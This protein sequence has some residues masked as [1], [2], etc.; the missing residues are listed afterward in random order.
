[1]LAVKKDAPDLLG[2][3]AQALFEKHRASDDVMIPK[4]VTDAIKQAL[5]VDPD[6]TRALFTRAMVFKRSGDMKKALAYFKRITQ[7]DPRHIE[8]QREVRL[9][10]LRADQE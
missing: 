8:A 1:M 5:D 4:L 6:N 10:K 3:R 9:A 2:L 7:I